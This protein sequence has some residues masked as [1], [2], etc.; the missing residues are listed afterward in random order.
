MTLAVMTRASLGHTGRMLTASSVTTAFYAAM[1]S[2]A[3]LRA[4]APVTPVHTELLLLSAAAWSAALLG[5]AI[6]F[7]PVLTGPRR[8]ATA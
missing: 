1:I 4:L 5:F 2:A 7:W 8:V 3:L 6:A